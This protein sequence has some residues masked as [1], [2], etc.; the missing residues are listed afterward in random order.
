MEKN[1]QEILNNS[2]SIPE[3]FFRIFKTSPNTPFSKIRTNLSNKANNDSNNDNSISFWNSIDTKEITHKVTATALYLKKIG[4]KKGSRVAI[5]SNSRLEWLIADLS[6]L[7]LGAV[8]VS[9]YQSLPEKEM[10]FI[11]HDSESRIVFAENQEQVD[12]LEKIKNNTWEMPKTELHEVRTL[13]VEINSVICFEEAK[14]S[15]LELVNLYELISKSSD[16]EVNVFTFD[17][18]IKREDLASLVY[19]SGTTGAPKGVMQT[20]GNHLS[21]VRQVLDS[22]LMIPGATIFLFLPLAHSFARLMGYLAALT[23]LSVS[24]PEVADSKTSKLIPAI[25]LRDMAESN[26]DIFPIVPRFLEKI[27]DQLLIQSEKKG[28]ASFLLSSTINNAKNFKSEPNNPLNKILYILLAPMRK[29]IRKKLFGSK[30][31]Y[32]VSG[33]AKLSVSVH[34][35]FDN[36]GFPIYEGYG[37]TETV[38]ATNAC[39]P[40]AQ[41]IGSV[42]KVLSSDIELKLLS[43]GEICYKGPNISPGYLNRPSANK[44]S[45]TED[46]WFLTGD[47]G[48][49]DNEGFLYITGRKKEIIVTSGGKNVAPLPIEEKLMD[50]SLISQAVVIGDGRKYCSAIITINKESIQNLASTRNDKP[51][52]LKPSSCEVIKKYIWEHINKVNHELSSFETIKK[53]VIVDD[54]F[55][56]ENG[57]LTPS[58]KIKRKEVEKRYSDEIDKLYS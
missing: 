41:K 16:D 2:A 35:F 7:S 12:K 4:V 48:N 26:S 21:N 50:S 34:E 54:E 20:H 18:T 52:I 43:D 6:I 49:I 5:I 42:G 17:N 47:V 10:A 9:I 14:A 45:W 29:V 51:E 8:S 58:M 31:K 37:L 25:I 27:K 56:I 15:T 23:D 24:F 22:G 46:G 1:K 3:E 39:K 33:G 32:C 57:L 36:L 30:F 13:G 19:T 53:I 11:L 40:N 28:L 44:E 55:S 38:V